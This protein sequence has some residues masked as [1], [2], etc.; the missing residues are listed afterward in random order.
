MCLFKNVFIKTINRCN[1]Y[2]KKSKYTLSI[3]SQYCP[4]SKN[5]FLK[6]ICNCPL[7][8]DIDW[9]FWLFFRTGTP[10]FAIGQRWW[11][12]WWFSQT[13]QSPAVTLEATLIGSYATLSNQWSKA[14]PSVTGPIKVTIQVWNQARAIY[15]K[16][17]HMFLHTPLWGN[18]LLPHLYTIPD[19]YVWA[20]L[21]NCHSKTCY[22][23]Q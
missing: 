4:H 19:P 17:P 18:P 23:G 13:R 16:P 9:N 15:R 5:F 7:V 12:L 11:S 6:V 14:H 1:V 10:N 2:C 8:C 21:R 3:N 22:V 20:N